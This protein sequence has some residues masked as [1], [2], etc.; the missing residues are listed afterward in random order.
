MHVYFSLFFASLSGVYSCI[1]TPLFLV[2]YLYKKNKF[3]LINLIILSFGTLTQIFLIL[4]S[5]YKNYLLESKF[6][7]TFD[8]Q[9]I[10]LFIYN[11]LIKPIFGRQLTHY[12]YEDYLSYFLS[13]KNLI[14]FIFIIILIFV[15]L[16]TKQL[17]LLIKDYVLLS[18]IYI[19]IVIS[20]LIIVGSIETHVGGRYAVIPGI[21]F[22]LIILRCVATFDQHFI[23]Y[24][25][26]FCISSSLINGLY[27]FRPP[28]QN[29]KHQYIKFLDC[30]DCPIWKE[31]VSKWRMDNSYLIKICRTKKLLDLI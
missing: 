12:I 14:I 4:Y 20:F 9:L 24:L 21:T 31:E 3:N 6:E 26:I 17:K 30:I 15:F 16:M 10:V 29:A 7:L 18:L 11:N 22:L 1:L 13:E 27:E 8:Y 28:T 2:K 23:K 25:A 19:F 5:R